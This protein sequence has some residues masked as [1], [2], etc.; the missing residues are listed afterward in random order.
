MFLLLSSIY[1]LFS[2]KKEY[3]LLILGLDNSGKSSFFQSIQKIFLKKEKKKTETTVGLDICNIPFEKVSLTFWDLGG[4]KELRVLWTD[5]YSLANGLLF[6]IDSSDRK[7]IEEAK[8]VFSH[9]VSNK[10]IKK[11]P[12]SVL[13]NKTDLFDSMNVLLIQSI[14]NPV[15]E[16]KCLSNVKIFCISAEKNQGIIEVLSW[17]IKRISDKNSFQTY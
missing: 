16:S 5:F 17:M 12:I 15:F 8:N 3:R 6:V 1:N 13:C 9:V 4:T 11:I 10:N 14:F 7:R 2:T